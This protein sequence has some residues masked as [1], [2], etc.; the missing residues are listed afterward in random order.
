MKKA[1]VFFG[2]FLLSATVAAAQVRTITNSTLQ[3]FQEKRI[4]ADREYRNNYE[5]MGFPSP[6]ELDRQR[7][8][9]MSA[10]LQLAEQLRRARL[11]KERLELEHRGLDLHAAAM[12]DDDEPYDRVG[13]FYGGYF[14]GIGGFSSGGGFRRRHGRFG[15]D[16]FAPFGGGYR[17]TPVGIIPDPSRRRIPFFSRGR[18]RGGSVIIRG[19]KR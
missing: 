18:G 10:R 2:L 14:G 12:N 6:E 5:R 7:E 3:R 9:D 15:F 16:R 19:S 11:E 17:A 13:G 8:N 1:V 4:A